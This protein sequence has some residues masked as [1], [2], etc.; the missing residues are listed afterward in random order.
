MSLPGRLLLKFNQYRTLGLRAAW[1]R[2]VVRPRILR[3]PPCVGLTDTRA[4]IHV[5]TSAGDWLNL[6]WALKSFYAASKR[7]YALCVHDD[8]TLPADALAQLRHHFQPV[9]IIGRAEADARMEKDL[10]AFPKLLQFRR[11][12]VLA[13][14]VTDFVAYLQSE[15]MML[16]DSD[17]LFFS[18]PT[19]FLR[20]MEDD[21]FALNAFN[22][23][24]S[25]AYVVTAEAT[26][27]HCGVNLKPR[28]NS[29]LGVVQRA[30]LRYDWMEEF[31]GIPGILD[32]HFWRIEQ[33]L[34]AL[35]S[36]KFG[37]AMLPEEYTVDISQ[38]GVGDRPSRHYI[39]CIR[40]RMYSEGI[41]QLTAGRT[42]NF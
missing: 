15:R 18:E 8:G 34:F 12:N 3:S 21:S 9:R 11:T 31:L 35:C 33:Q 6:M 16:L 10:A 32:G 25:D 27:S 20:L 5:M 23:D 2:D 26:Q 37:V 30:S 42:A 29:G 7:K 38:A 14:K 36:S 24:C 39:G 19:A 41:R 13:P 28:I 40:S 1:Y 4:E 17:I 22:S